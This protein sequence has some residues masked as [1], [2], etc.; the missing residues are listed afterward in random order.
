[1]TWARIDDLLPHHPKLMAAQGSAPA[2]F[3]LYV[4]SIC[5]ARRH[6]SDGLLLRSA[7]PILLPACPHPSPKIIKQL[8]TLHLWDPLPD[9]TGWRVHDFLEWNDSAEAIRQ[10]R[11]EDSARK[12]QS[13]PRGLRQDSARSPDGFQPASNS[14]SRGE[15]RSTRGTPPP[16]ETQT[17]SQ[18]QTERSS[19]PVNSPPA[20]RGHEAGPGSP[21]PGSDRTDV[22]PGSTPRVDW[23]PRHPPDPAKVAA[24]L[25]AVA[26]RPS[27]P[28]PRTENLTRLP[29]HPDTPVP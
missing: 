2:V 12:R 21:P 9:G 13:R 20:R 23:L 26:A 7:L 18:T 4:A 10:K 25:A 19:V 29:P 15:E 22:A 14:R 24:Y 6:L 11:A 8:E 5:Y 27:D 16:E 28:A 17:Q 1:M 3:G